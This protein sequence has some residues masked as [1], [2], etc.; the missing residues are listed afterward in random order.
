MTDAA[1]FLAKL[2]RERDCFRQFLEILERE[3]EV[4]VQ[5]QVDTLTD[6]AQKK[7]GKVL[8]LA[9]LAEARNRFLAGNGLPPDQAG[10]SAWLGALGNAPEAQEARRA[11]D[12]L[13]AV[14]KAARQLNETNGAMI[15]LQ[16][17]HNQ[18]ALAVL[19]SAANQAALYGPD[20]QRL[21]GGGGR[22]FDKA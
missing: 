17:Q 18:Q 11:W 16:L 2:S 12:E 20:G 13:V 5:G 19:M 8:E 14:A 7:S 3:Q 9:Q 4:L 10:V 21:S 15:E 22:S 6:I 1:G